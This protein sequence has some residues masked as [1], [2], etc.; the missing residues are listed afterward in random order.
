MGE[1]LGV[2]SRLLNWESWPFFLGMIEK[3]VRREQ[4]EM[5]MVVACSLS[6]HCKMEKKSNKKV[7]N[8]LVFLTG[9]FS[10]LLTFT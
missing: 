5:P 7:I 3:Q 9:L 2:C 6:C 1:Q 4:K 10:I 8:T